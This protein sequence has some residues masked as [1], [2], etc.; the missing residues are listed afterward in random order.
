MG[1]PQIGPWNVRTVEL[2][3][4]ETAAG[5]FSALPLLVYNRTHILN[6]SQTLAHLR[7]ARRTKVNYS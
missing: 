5:R 4:H 6:S 2:R 7:S 1:H 3:A